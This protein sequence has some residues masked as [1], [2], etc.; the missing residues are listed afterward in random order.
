MRYVRLTNGAEYEI[1]RCGAAQGVLW[2]GVKGI[3][4]AQA[5]SVFSQPNLTAEIRSYFSFG[6]EEVF[7][8][9]T[10]LIVVQIDDEGVLVALRKG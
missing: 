3:T 5:A 10:D 9:Y 2:I 1:Y 6:M 8:G 4:V 7:T